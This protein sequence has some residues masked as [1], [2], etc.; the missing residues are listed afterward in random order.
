MTRFPEPLRPDRTAV[1]VP[2][3]AADAESLAAQCAQVAALPAGT[4]DLVEWRLDRYA[5]VVCSGEFA[6]GLEVLRR[7]LPKMPILGCY[8]TPDEEGRPG[9]RPDPPAA[10]PDRPDQYLDLVSRLT[11]A[12]AFSLVDVQRGHP[13]ARAA[14]DACTA[15]GMPVVL[16][17]HHFDGPLPA[18]ETARVFA[19][20][21]AELDGAAGVAK[22]AVSPHTPAE[23]TELMHATAI[24]AAQLEMPLVAIAMGPLGR[25]TRIGASAF[26]SAMSYCTA[27]AGSAPG[28]VPAETARGILDLLAAK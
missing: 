15:A 17:E 22:L 16:S 5:E 28:Q 8:R 20:M 19:A 7:A 13:Q 21:A 10:C 4:V 27:G 18:G 2:L 12:G 25:I 11:A 9:L 1:V 3:V 24:S 14:I 6:G 26:G 23:V